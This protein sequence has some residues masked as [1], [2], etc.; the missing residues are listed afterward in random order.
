MLITNI[1]ISIPLLLPYRPLKYPYGCENRNLR[2]I[3]P[4]AQR[5]LPLLV[6]IE[7]EPCEYE[8]EERHQDGHGHGAAVGG[9]A[10][11]GL[12]RRDVLPHAHACRGGSPT[13]T[14]RVWTTRPDQRRP[15]P[16]GTGSGNG[17]PVR[18]GTMSRM[19][20]MRT[21]T[22][23]MKMTLWMSWRE[24]RRLGWRDTLNEDDDDVDDD[25]DD[26]DDDTWEGGGIGPL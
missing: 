12:H 25:D 2:T 26:D 8:G 13:H 14:T 11:L 10:G 20:M 24:R 1:L 15:A 6:E 9:A 19:W 22:M 7:A 5:A 18:M 16:S 4:Q 21:M 17:K 3:G 23:V